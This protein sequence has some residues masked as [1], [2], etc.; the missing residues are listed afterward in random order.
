MEQDDTKLEM[1]KDLSE[2]VAGRIY[3]FFVHSEKVVA[4]H[5]VPSNEKEDPSHSN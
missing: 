5:T 1:E 3:F 4:V 2:H